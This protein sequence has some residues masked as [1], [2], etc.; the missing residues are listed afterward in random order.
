MTETLL[1][2][3]NNPHK[4]EEFRSIFQLYEVILQTPA[5]LGLVNDVEESGST[6]FENARLKA[7]AYWLDGQNMIL[8]DDSGLEVEALE[9]APGIHS[10]RFLPDPNATSHDRC[11]YL[12]HR[13]KDFPR[14]WRAEFHCEVVLLTRESEI[15]TSHGICTG[16][17]IPEFR[18]ENGFGYD[19]IFLVDGSNQ[20]MAELDPDTK[21]RLS[22]RG[23]AVLGMITQLKLPLRQA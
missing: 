4:V 6:Y 16:E 7:E 18:G 3:T 5:D 9:G 15:L 14:P 21:N 20:T 23:K 17:I 12:L 8:A 1:L 2:A 13:L 22:H 10:H 11:L 19:P